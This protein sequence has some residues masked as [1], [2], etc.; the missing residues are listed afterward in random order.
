MTSVTKMRLN[1]G[2][3]RTSRLGAGSIE[4]ALGNIDRNGMRQP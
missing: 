2:I 4:T 3:R 1:Q